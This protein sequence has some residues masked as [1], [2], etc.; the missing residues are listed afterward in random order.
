[1]RKTIKVY[2]DTSVFGGVFDEEFRE[3]SLEFFYQVKEGRFN[4]MTSG[5][6][7]AEIQAAPPKIIDF[8]EEMLL[9]SEV[10][11]ISEE[12]LRLR[13]EYLKSKIVLK[14]YSNDALHVALASV[15]D[16]RLI[17]SW[18]FQHIVHFDK[19]PLYNAFNVLLGYHEI[20]IHSPSGVIHYE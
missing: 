9:Y 20:L 7:Q 13:D 8:F 2:A 1:M 6:V 3:H 10:I 5:V 12:A 17:V 19:I 15:S 18:N 16:C 4:L 11:D 14:K